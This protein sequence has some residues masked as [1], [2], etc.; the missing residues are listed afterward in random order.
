MIEIRD[1][2][3]RYGSTEVVKDFSLS[4]P[5]GES[6]ALWGPNGAGKTTVVRCI[7]G[8]VAYVRPVCCR[9]G[10]GCVFSNAK[11]R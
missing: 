8:L 7:L 10:R 2:T 3:K 4:I 1:L 5:E 11:R 9:R 6:V